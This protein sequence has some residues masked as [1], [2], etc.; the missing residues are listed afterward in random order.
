MSII[1]KQL[2]LAA[3]VAAMSQ[4]QASLDM[5]NT[6]VVVPVSFVIDLTKQ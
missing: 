1:P 2:L 6:P 3:I 5:E 4:G